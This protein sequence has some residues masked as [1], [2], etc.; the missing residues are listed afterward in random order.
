MEN[1]IQYLFRISYPVIKGGTFFVHIRTEGILYLVTS[2]QIDYKN[3]ENFGKGWELIL[4]C[5]NP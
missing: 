4:W 1:G 3:I 2:F 5:S